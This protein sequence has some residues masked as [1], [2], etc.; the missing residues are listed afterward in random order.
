MGHESRGGGRVWG[1][2]VGQGTYLKC[3]HGE[4]NVT[5]YFLFLFLVLKTRDMVSLTQVLVARYVLGC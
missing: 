1:M 4:G 5:N 3:S 2:W